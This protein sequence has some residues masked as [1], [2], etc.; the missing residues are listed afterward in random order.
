M[1]LL[2]ETF[3]VFPCHK[4]FFWNPKWQQACST[5]QI[6]RKNQWMKNTNFFNSLNGEKTSASARCKAKVGYQTG[7]GTES[8]YFPR[9]SPGNVEVTWQ[10]HWQLLRDQSSMDFMLCGGT[11]D[12]VDLERILGDL[13][14]RQR[15]RIACQRRR[16]LA[17][18][19]MHVRAYAAFVPRD[20][21]I[22]DQHQHGPEPWHSALSVHRCKCGHESEQREMIVSM[23]WRADGFCFF[24]VDSRQPQ[25]SRYTLKTN[26]N[27]LLFL[28]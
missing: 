2:T 12:T 25:I 14:W 17:A 28:L 23:A 19:V 18:T 20:A 26:R 11:R 1:V 22:I 8:S 3:Y 9:R 21:S 27:G 15:A 16:P 10:Q 6:F 4:I 13:P 24:T 5:E 7:N